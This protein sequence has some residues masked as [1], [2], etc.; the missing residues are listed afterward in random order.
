MTRATSG[1]VFAKMEMGCGPKEPKA[2][3]F[4]SSKQV[5]EKCEDEWLELEN[6][7]EGAES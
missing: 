2:T 5:P 7:R 3:E 6:L 1:N 4:T